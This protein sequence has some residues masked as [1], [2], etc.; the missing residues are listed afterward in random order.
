M[1]PWEIENRIK[2]L[3]RRVT[4]MEVK[5][6]SVGIAKKPEPER[7]NLEEGIGNVLQLMCWNLVSDS[8]SCSGAMCNKGEGSNRLCAGLKQ[9]LS[10]ILLFFGSSSR[11][12]KIMCTKCGKYKAEWDIGDDNLCQMCFEAYCSDEYWRF[13]DEGKIV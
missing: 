11:G 13:V 6:D 12:G 8:I 2:E 3:E 9:H 7:G 1:H 5:V 10:Q 4:D